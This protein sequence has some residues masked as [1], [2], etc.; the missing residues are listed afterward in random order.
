M[1]YRSDVVI[2]LRKDALDNFINNY[3]TLIVAFEFIHGSHEMT[4]KD[5]D[6]N[7]WYLFA[8]RSVKWYDDFPEVQAINKF[9]NEEEHHSN[10]GSFEY[11]V[12]GEN[13]DDYT[14]INQGYSPFDIYLSRTLDFS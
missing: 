8:W 5:S 10:E 3:C 6:E 7:E 9:M 4:R 14:Q 12:M 13:S 1:G 2:A 11:H